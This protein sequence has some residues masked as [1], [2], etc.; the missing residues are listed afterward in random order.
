[1][2]TKNSILGSKWFLKEV[3]ERKGLQ[4]SQKYK[5][6]ILLSNLLISRGINDEEIENFLNPNLSNNLPDPFLLIDME[7][8]ILRI[9]KAIKNNEKIGIIA[10][11]DVDG[12]ASAAIFY[13]FLINFVAKLLIKI[14]NRLSE[15]YGPNERILNE[16]K[17]E[18]IKVIVTLDCGTSAKGLIDNNKYK[19][20]DFIVIDH[21]LSEPNLPN[22][23]SL[24]NPN[25][26]DEHNNY[27][28]MAAVG[29]TFLFLMGL[30]K[31]L[32]DINFFKK[33]NEPNLMN[34]LDL[35]ALGTVCDVVK[36]SFH[37][38]VFVSKGLEL[39][40]KRKNLVITKIL[41][42]SN[43]QNTPTTSDLGFKIGPQLN[44][45]SRIDDSSLAANL[46]IETDINKIDLITR[47][48][49]LLNEKRKVIENK[50]F[51][52]ANKQAIK[53]K[54]SNYILV[55]G[56]DWHNGVLGIVASKLMSMYNKPSIVISFVN[57]IGI[58]SARSIKNIDFGTIII[59]AK[60]SN[61][62]NKGG[63]HSMAAGFEINY[64]NL[65]KF[66]DFLFNYMNKIDLSIFVKNDLHDSILSINEVN[67]DIL[68]MINRMEPFGNGNPEPKFIIKD[69]VIDNIKIV[70]EKHIFLFFKNDF[71]SNL[72][73]ICFNC[74]G[75]DLGEYLLK[76][77]KFKFYF[78]CKIKID[79]FNNFLK[80]QLLIDDAMVIN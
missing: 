22:V 9:I 32:R 43:N 46:L 20:I 71:N 40:R 73:A 48:L 50:I 56:Y 11:Y 17:N 26:F 76:F 54:K 23:Y 21:H 77:K 30:R 74:I 69:I 34:L 1:V 3:D 27:N 16:M 52:E 45:A 24:I 79:N 15:G 47:K 65:K 70:K 12:S 6:P 75:T 67:H 33:I 44:A 49:F 64:N 55:Y 38:R 41:D 8:G 7:K 60:N 37:N 66:N 10:D 19:N 29:V 72:K 51:N 14:P 13:K 57:N 31:K 68:E 59:N 2:F 42:N 18:G 53:Q 63:G 62:I 80:P 61:L 25:R 39:I 36:L 5:I 35:V 58:A 28:D 4:I 78:S